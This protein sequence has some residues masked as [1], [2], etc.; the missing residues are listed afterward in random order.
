MTLSSV[1]RGADGPDV[2]VVTTWHAGLPDA[3]ADFARH[4]ALVCGEDGFRWPL[5]VALEQGREPGGNPRWRM[6]GAP[7]LLIE[8]GVLLEG[9]RFLQTL[10]ALPD[11]PRL[12]VHHTSP[13]QYTGKFEY[14]NLFDEAMRAFASYEHHVC[15]SSNVISEWKRIDGL[16][17][18]NWIYIPNC[19]P[20]EEAER[21]L[22]RDRAICARVSGCRARP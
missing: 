19:A 2:V 10:P 8:E 1:L 6:A 18:K 11:C 16:G 5:W 4:T 22:R 15:V 21:L 9:H 3:M 13:D 14:R 17:E 7:D 20:E 12:F